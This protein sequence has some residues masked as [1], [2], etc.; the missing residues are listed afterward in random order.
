MAP[1]IKILLLL[2]CCFFTRSYAGFNTKLVGTWVLVDKTAINY[3][4]IAFNKN[5][6]A[7]FFSK[8]DT[9]YRYKYEL[10]ENG[11]IELTDNKDN[12][13]INAIIKFDNDSLMFDGL[14]NQKGK[15]LYIKKKR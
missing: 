10:Q 8:G 15:Q 14:P 12:K 7:I 13:Y 9:I 5:A 11:T 2:V 1:K 4:E 6:M 3:P